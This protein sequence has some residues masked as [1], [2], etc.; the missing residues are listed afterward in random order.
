M[1]SLDNKNVETLGTVGG[2][3]SNSQK[4]KMMKDIG[5][6]GLLLLARKVRQ[7]STCKEGIELNLK[8]VLTGF[9]HMCTML[10]WET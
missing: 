5:Q 4:E 3:S 6:W 7:K 1:H 2:S 10:C 8:H 9:G